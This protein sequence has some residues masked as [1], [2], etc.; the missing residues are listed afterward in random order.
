MS[1]WKPPKF[2]SPV[3]LG[4]SAKDLSRAEKFY[5]TVFN[6]S[7]RDPKLPTP[8]IN[9]PEKSKTRLF[10]FNPDISLSGGIQDRPE[11][12][13]TGTPAAGPGGTCVYWLVED[14]DKIAEVIEK[15]GGRM[16][17]S[18]EPVKEGESGLYRYFE[19]TEGNVGGVYQFLG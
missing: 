11:R 4:I 7:F 2:G 3:W 8:N 17:G 13:G 5:A 9:E 10:D 19:D 6:W 18:K 12:D 14:L 1:D 15:A 16:V